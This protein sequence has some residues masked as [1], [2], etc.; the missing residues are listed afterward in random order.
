M[1]SQTNAKLQM[2]H[3]QLDTD[4]WMINANITL[5]NALSQGL[6]PTANSPEH[7]SLQNRQ[8][9]LDVQLQEVEIAM[10]KPL[11]PQRNLQVQLLP[12]QGCS[13]TSFNRD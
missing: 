9:K 3:D 11:W 6:A 2:N 5:I 1:A 12:G 10:P 8:L 13:R 7:L 4:N